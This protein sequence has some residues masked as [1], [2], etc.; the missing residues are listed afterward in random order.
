MFYSLTNIGKPRVSKYAFTRE[1]MTKV[2]EYVK[3]LSPRLILV[4]HLKE[5]MLEKAG[6][7]FTS[8]EIDLTGKV[9]RI[10]T[11]QSDAIGYMYRKSGN[12]NVISFATSDSVACGAR[13]KHLSNAEIEISQLKDGVLTTH[14]EKIYID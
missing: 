12:I 5:T 1:A 3:T 2:I 7:E 11:S 8:N 9:K 14:W 6:A 4:C 10:L 13:P